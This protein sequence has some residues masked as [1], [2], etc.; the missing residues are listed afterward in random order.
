MRYIRIS[1]CGA[2]I[3]WEEASETWVDILIV[4]RGGESSVVLKRFDP[5]EGSIQAK[6]RP[7]Q[8][9][10]TME[11]RCNAVSWGLTLSE[12]S[13]EASVDSSDSKPN[14]PPSI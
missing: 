13:F 10:E 4:G 12:A 7:R 1:G 5:G 9:F 8:R 2:A 11:Q 14:D 6:F 3:H